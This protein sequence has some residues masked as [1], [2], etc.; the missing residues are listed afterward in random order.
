MVQKCST[1]TIP[2]TGANCIEKRNA[3]PPQTPPWTS[4]L[5][6]DHRLNTERQARQPLAR[7]T[8]RVCPLS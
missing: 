5:A 3:L 7:T 1:F 8:D 2:G 6:R 4:D